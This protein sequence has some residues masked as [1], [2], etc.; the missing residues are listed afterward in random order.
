MSRT[1]P[2]RAQSVPAPL[3]PSWAGRLG[4]WPVQVALLALAVALAYGRTFDVPFYLDDFSSIQENVPIWH[5]QGFEAVRQYQPTRVVGYLSF[6]L[7]YRLGHFIPFGYHLVNLL[8]HFLAGVAVFGCA[9]GLLRTPRL[10][11][12]APPLARAALPLL[13]AG[14][15]VLHP[16]QTEAVTYIVQRLTSLAGLLYIACMAAYLK[17]RLASA[18][19]ARRLW[20]ALCFVLAFLAFFTKENTGTLPLALFL[21]ELVFFRHPPGRQ[22]ALAGAAAAGLALVW[23]IDATSHGQGALSLASIQ[24]LTTVTQEF[25]RSQYF[26]TQLTVL[27]HY[28]RLFVWPSGLH[29][30]YAREPASG[31]ASAGVL[32]AMAGHLLVVGLAL[33]AW[34]RRPLVTW[35]VLFYYLAHAVE[36]SVVPI[37][38]LVFEHRTYLPNLGL[39][40]LCGWVITAELPRLPGGARAVLPLVLLASLAL[41]VATWRRNEVWRDPLAFWQDDVRRAPAKARAWGNLGKALLAANRP[42]DA[43]RALE[44]SIRLERVERGST[45]VDVLSAINLVM[46]LQTMN[47]FDRA[48]ELIR[49]TLERPMKPPMRATLY[50]NRGIIRLRQRQ[51]TEAE[52]AFREALALHPYS[53]PAMANLASTWA[54]SGHMAKAES[55]YAQVLEIDPDDMVTRV[56]FLQARVARLLEA[57]AAL[58]KAHRESDAA[59]AD[60]AALEALDQLERAAPADSTV[61]ATVRE[62][63]QLIASGASR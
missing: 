21:I 26:A 35:A 38:D 45:Q 51:F 37:N 5:W 20:A 18:G 13:A 14:L 33:W 27:W 11:G 60:R 4:A 63:R 32:L 58:R 44:E 48:L 30:E 34:R 41:G 50:I 36:S 52:A 56:N 39:C 57:G 8:I 54:Q 7:N 10:A 25:P 3:A 62:A 31:F 47:Q 53:L 55:L 49:S 1:P 46:A 2:R 22:V 40:L 43:A 59:Q 24:S 17:A 12:A 9:R 6:A 15:F 42:A 16:L 29:L 19:S 61:Q 23:L 28:L